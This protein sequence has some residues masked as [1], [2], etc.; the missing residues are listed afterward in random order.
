[1]DIWFLIDGSGSIGMHD[2]QTAL[3]LVVELSSAFPISPDYVRA[4]FSVYDSSHTFHSRFDENASN[5][6]FSQVVLSASYPAGE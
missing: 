3:Q 4:G 1:M 5:S 6:E 2:F